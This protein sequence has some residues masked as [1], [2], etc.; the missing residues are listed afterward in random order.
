MVRKRR[1]TPWTPRDEDY[2]QLLQEQSPW[3]FNGQVPEALAFRV[4][5][6]LAASLWKRV[7]TNRPRRSHLVLGPRRVG[8]TTAMYQTVRSLLR[9]GIEPT[10]L[11]WFRLDHPLL[12]E[13]DLGTL[14]RSQLAVS[15]ATQEKPLFLF[16]DELTYSKEWDLW[17]KTFHDEQWPVCVI[18]S[19]SSTAALKKR[20]SES[21]VG[22]WEEQHLAPYLFPEYLALIEKLVPRVA[23]ATLSST[24]EVLI[25][26]RVSTV[27]L[28]G[29]RDLYLLTGGFPELIIDLGNH[30][31]EELSSALLRSQRILREDAVVRAIYKDIPQAFS[32]DNPLMLERVLYTLAGEVTGIL[33]PMKICQSLGLTQ[34]TFDRYLS[35][36][37]QAF[38]VFTLPNY[39]GSERAKQRR[40]RKLYFVDG[41]IRNAALQRGVLPL[42]NPQEMGLL[43]EN[44]V[45]GHLHALSQQSLVRVHHWRDRADEVDFI[46]DHPEHPLAFEIASS[47]SHSRRGIRRF[48]ERFPR[49]RERCY[50][51]AP[52]LTPTLPGSTSDGVGTLPL[53]L[54]LL[55]VG[56]QAGYHLEQRLSVR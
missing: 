8:K 36:L 25:Q 31:G 28:S 46:Y 51:V 18:G 54:L 11:P 7:I 13:R 29:Q 20:R 19:S 49:F 14:V 5:R 40:G 2:G 33:S 35:Y 26:E 3:L 37:E 23:E 43:L 39:S 44:L 55:A 38:L 4:E 53:D 21:G 56:W 48:L 17:L 22:R 1:T 32:I 16:L 34:P 15:K 41:A 9:S 52:D 12:I 45:A 42:S 6:P 47:G 27:G 50:L 10:R 30:P 24:I